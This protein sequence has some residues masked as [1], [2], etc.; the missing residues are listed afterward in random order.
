MTVTGTRNKTSSQAPHL[1]LYPSATLR[2]P[3]SAKMPESGTAIE[4]NGTPWAA[5]YAIVPLEKWPRLAITKINEK[6]ILPNRTTCFIQVTSLLQRSQNT[7]RRA[8]IYGQAAPAQRL[9]N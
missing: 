5:A 8:G 7:A 6:R 2:P 3:R 1:A 4:A 9:D